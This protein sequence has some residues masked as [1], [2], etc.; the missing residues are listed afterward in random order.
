VPGI[1]GGQPFEGLDDG[2]TVTLELSNV[3]WNPA[4]PVN[5]WMSAQAALGGITPRQQVAQEIAFV[6]GVAR[7]VFA[8]PD[9]ERLRV[10]VGGWNAQASFL[11]G[12]LDALPADFHVDA[13]GP[14]AYITPRPPVISGWLEGA[15]PMM[16]TCPNCPTPEEVVEGALLSLTQLR[17]FV[18]NHRALAEGY[19][20]PD[21]S[22][23]VVELYEAGH[24]FK[25]GL[26]PWAGAALV[27]HTIPELYAAYVDE[28]IP[29]FED[30]GVALA[31]WYSFMS[32]QTPSA[33]ITP[34]GTWDD[35]DQSITLP[36][37]NVYV[38]E[39]APK[40]A[41]IYRG[42]PIDDSCAPA[43]ATFRN[44]GTNPTSFTLAA[45]VVGGPFDA[46]VDL[47]TTGHSLAAL[48]ATTDAGALLLPSG[49]TLLLADPGA[50]GELLG[51]DLRAGP[52]ASWNLTVPA[53]AAL[54]GFAASLQAVH[55]GGVVPFA[56]S[57][58]QDVV[59]GG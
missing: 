8:G 52:V 29:M 36:V 1:N 50:Q 54:C 45:P 53:T 13:I 35:M 18:Q 44:A 4:F 12:V 19:V 23:P 57:N 37:P 47:T 33:G 41:A 40:A 32:D 2:L 46:T 5:P 51:L 58:A 11:T 27:A 48:L 24:S 7:S 39:G 56:L 59:F 31:I 42:P 14:Q 30:E 20:N 49:Q 15:D 10:F 9:E 38:D 6:A 17:T 43:S 22:S 3:M 28:L 16:G 26:Q 34:F 55:L 25:A 21:G